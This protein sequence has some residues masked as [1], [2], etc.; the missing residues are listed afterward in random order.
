MAETTPPPNSLPYISRYDPSLAVNIP[1]DNDH[2]QHHLSSRSPN[3]VPQSVTPNTDIE[4]DEDEKEYSRS[5]RTSNSGSRSSSDSDREESMSKMEIFY[6]RQ[7][8]Y[9]K[10][11]RK[12]IKKTRSSNIIFTAADILPP[13]KD[14]NDNDNDN[15]DDD[16]I[17]DEDFQKILLNCMFYTNYT[18]C[19]FSI[20]YILF[21]P[22]N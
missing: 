16:E 21:V 10:N 9:Q 22:T 8:K 11:N 14:D 7:Q 19:I 1:S 13:N 17:E 5:M 20:Y 6:H 15:D 3:S 18:F 4:D 2:H 12:H